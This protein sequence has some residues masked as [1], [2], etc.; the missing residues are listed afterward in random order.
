MS[1][2][3]AGDLTGSLT[4]WRK[5]GASTVATINQASPTYG[6]GGGGGNY[7]SAEER[8]AKETAMENEQMLAAT[9][10]QQGEQIS[11]LQAAAQGE[12]PS[13]AQDQLQLATDQNMRQSLA[14]AAS[15]RGNPALAMQAAGQQR[16]VMGQQL[17]SQSGALRA[18]EM[19]AA[20][21][22]LAQ[23][24]QA[25]R[26]QD[27]GG[28]NVEL[29]YAQV[30]SQENIASE[31]RATQ[32]GIARDANTT[33]QGA[34]FLNAIG[35]GLG[36]FAA[37]SDE[38]AKKDINKVSDSEVDEFYEALQPKGYNYK[39][40]HAAGQSEGEKIGMM[41][42]DVDQ[43]ALGKKLFTEQADGM[44]A[45]DPQVLDGILLAGMKKLMKD[46]KYGNT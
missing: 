18:Q 45:Y 6:G 37:L 20:Q 21:G 5:R 42:Q 26:Q 25:Q 29:G 41:A 24:I 8:A 4:G 1:S 10:L 43:T 38:R 46:Q 28:Q 23:A 40:P 39:D 36:A 14:M 19:N 22:Q 16:G 17:V 44:K 15:G 35:S 34:G 32:R 33:A 13:A 2:G 30:A 11:A 3:T 12:G 9:R 7:D 31:N 27:L